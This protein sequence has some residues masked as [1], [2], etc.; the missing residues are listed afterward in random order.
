MGVILLLYLFKY[1]LEYDD[2][3]EVVMQSR[4]HLGKN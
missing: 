1:C 3:L 2:L 4:F